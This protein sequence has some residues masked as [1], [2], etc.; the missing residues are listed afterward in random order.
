MFAIPL[1]GSE[2]KLNEQLPKA[3]VDFCRFLDGLKR[4]AT[5]DVFACREAAVVVRPLS[6]GILLVLLYI[7]SA[8]LI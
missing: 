5:P 1:A 3:Q 2:S 4:V 8:K 6:R 7:K